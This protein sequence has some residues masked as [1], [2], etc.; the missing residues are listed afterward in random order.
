MDIYERQ[1]TPLIRPIATD[2]D[3]TGDS[4][5]HVIKQ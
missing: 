3:D 2:L 1:E 5:A 4:V